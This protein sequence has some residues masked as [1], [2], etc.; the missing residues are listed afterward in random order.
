MDEPS[1]I[2]AVIFYALVILW[3][4]AMIAWSDSQGDDDE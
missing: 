2:C 1:V 3:L 4:V